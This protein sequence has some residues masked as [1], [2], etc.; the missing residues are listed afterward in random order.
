MITTILL[1]TVSIGFAA[2]VYFNPPQNLSFIQNPNVITMNYSREAMSDLQVNLVH[3]MTNGYKQYQLD[4]IKKA[5]KDD[6]YSIWFDLETIKKFVY[7]V[8]INAKNN[9]V[10][11]RDLG[12]RIYYSR[13]PEME[14]WQHQYTDLADFLNDPETTKYQERHTLVMIPTINK[15]GVQMDFNPKDDRTYTEKMEL[16]PEYQATSTTRSIPALTIT[17]GNGGPNNTPG[18]NHGSLIPPADDTGESF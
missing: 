18:Q 13:Y 4:Y 11:S 8:E 9:G 5:M 10:S 15:E 17:I 16:F 2:Y 1:I 6:A 14:T 7:H 12:L 3:D